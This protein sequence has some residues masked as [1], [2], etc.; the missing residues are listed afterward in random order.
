MEGKDRFGPPSY[1]TWT[2]TSP[3]ES[4]AVV[5]TCAGCTMQPPRAVEHTRADCAGRAVRP[6]GRVTNTLLQLCSQS[7][8][9]LSPG[10]A[11]FITQERASLCPYK[12]RPARSLQTALILLPGASQSDATALFYAGTL[13]KCWE[14]KPRGKQK[15]EGTRAA[16]SS[17]A[18]IPLE[19]GESGGFMLL[20]P[21]C[22]GGGGAGRRPL[23]F[24]ASN[25][26][27][28]SAR[29]AVL[30][31]EISVRQRCLDG[32]KLHG[33]S[34]PGPSCSHLGATLF[35]KRQPLQR[36]NRKEFIS[37]RLRFHLSAA[38]TTGFHG[39]CWQQRAGQNSDRRDGGTRSGGG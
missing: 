38:G 30:P 39:S 11:G 1:N 27:E 25:G 37:V 6:E 17:G 32:E 13:G 9:L 3:A 14:R 10:R 7:C 31:A 5:L 22:V 26:E 28:G 29:R 23:A 16:C 21:M 33:F 12:A 15:L 18:K 4:V 20:K 2:R 19:G 36:T 8:V 35:Q 24:A 34:E